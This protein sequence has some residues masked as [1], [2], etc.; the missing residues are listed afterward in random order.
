[1][2]PLGLLLAALVIPL[3][4][5]ALSATAAGTAA[6]KVVDRTPL[7]IEG[8]GFAARRDVTV[9]VQAPGTKM[10]RTVRASATG[11]FSVAI[12]LLS[13]TGELRCATGVVISARSKS[14]GVVLWHQTLP[15]CSDPLRPLRHRRPPVGII[16]PRPSLPDG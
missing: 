11:R 15:N 2:R 4:I 16:G 7:T 12:R 5:A 13:L 9:T 6:L 3:A 8:R 1:M 14:S 10:R